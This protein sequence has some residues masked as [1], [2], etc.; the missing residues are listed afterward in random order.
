MKLKGLAAV[1]DKVLE[2]QEAINQMIDSNDEDQEHKDWDS[3]NEMLNAA[4][5]DL[6]TA[7]EALDGIR[8]LKQDEF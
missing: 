6:D 5:M 1:I 7:L 2:L 8:E 3:R 4:Y